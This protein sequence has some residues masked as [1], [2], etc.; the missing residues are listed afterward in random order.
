MNHFVKM[1]ASVDLFKGLS[2]REVKEIAEAGK[3]VE[4]GAGERFVE[5]GLQASDFY[6]IVDGQAMLSVPKKPDRLLGPGDS[7]GEISVLDGGPRTATVTAETQVLT[8]RLDRQHFERLLDDHGSIGR[9][10]LV[11]MCGRLRY[12]ESRMEG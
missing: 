11:E 12:A 9:K 7:F 6:L 8:F 5:A 4:F 3:Q 1:L 2:R 10:I